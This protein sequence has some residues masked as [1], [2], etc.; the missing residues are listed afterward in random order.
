M[1]LAK[2]LLKAILVPIV[3]VVVLAAVAI[4]AFKQ[5]RDKKKRNKEI[6]QQA[7]R[8]PPLVQWVP[9]DAVQKPAATYTS[10]AVYPN[11]PG[12]VEKGLARA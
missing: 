9:P 11:T 3:V 2:V 10:V 4:I 12:Q 1:G 7:F 6:Q 8:P 5:Y